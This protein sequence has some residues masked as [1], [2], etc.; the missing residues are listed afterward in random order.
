M[1][2]MNRLDSEI[3]E[4]LTRYIENNISNSD[5]S[6]ETVY[7]ELGVSKTRLHRIVKDNT[8][9]STT[10]Y[11]RHVRLE[12][13]KALLDDSNLRI[14]EI[15]SLVG[16]DS[17]QN[18]SK[19]FIQ[20]YGLSPTEYRKR[21]DNVES[22]EEIKAVVEEELQPVAVPDSDKTT[23]R[24]KWA[25]FGLFVVMVV[26]GGAYWI[27]GKASSGNS[28]E[29]YLPHFDN[30]IAILPFKSL[31]QETALADGVLEGIHS[32][33]SL[34]EN[35][36][37]ISQSSSSQ[38]RDTDKTNWQIGD[39]L[40]VAYVLKG[41]VKEQSNQVETVLSLIRTQDDI[42]VWSQRYEGNLQQLFNL[43]N[44]MVKDIATQLSQKITPS[45]SQQLERV[46]TRN[47]EAYNEFL[48]GRTLLITRTKEKL[49]ES[50]I[51]FNKALTL[52]T[53]FAE[54][55]AYKSIAYLLMGNMGYQDLKTCLELA[56]QHALK[57]IQL[58]THNST[59]Y[60]TLGNVYRGNFKWQ[61]SKTAYEISLK[62]RPN[63]AQT[64]YWY[65]LLLRSMGRLSE[66]LRYSTKAVL[67]DPLYPVI[68]SGHIWNC[69]YANRDDLAQKALTDGKLIFDDSFVY[70]MA[71]GEYEL[72]HNRYDKALKEFTKME[73][74]NPNIKYGS[75]SS[76]FCAARLG[77][78]IPTRTLLNKMGNQAQDFVSKSMLY[79]GLGQ[80]DSSLICLE[81]AASMGRISSEI[82]VT[83]MYRAIRKD[84]RF[85][86]VLRQFGLPASATVQ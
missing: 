59:A 66:A 32:S 68:L 16:I 44:G 40:Q 81:K 80:K 27:K 33:L 55:Q 29:N 60:A 3:L 2:F 21:K 76:A 62:Y 70:Y 38:Y 15:A 11:I 9:L 82:L 58:D 43:M 86:S 13:S 75:V 74:L 48:L 52:D 69:A 61:Q 37:V 57:A 72:H 1:P 73:Q 18:F 47:L 5:F 79:A 67:L 20:A 83:P 54:A 25:L 56:E 46:P 65:S 36:K 31:N 39:E 22:L 78:P 8:Q 26:I 41:T 35:L 42:E 19:Y 84:P 7:K 50:L 14:T 24:W 85:Q 45:Q 4:K 30:S 51:R 77:N 53:T 64:I 63:D 17:P 23:G 49:N 6:L 71:R 10:L 28:S 12:K 34:I